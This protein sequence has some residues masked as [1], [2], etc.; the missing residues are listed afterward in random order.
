VSD[1]S[2]SVSEASAGLDCCFHLVNGVVG[3]SKVDRELNIIGP[4]ND[5]FDDSPYR[6]HQFEVYRLYDY[7]HDPHGQDYKGTLNT[8][9]FV[10]IK[11]FF[12]DGQDFAYYIIGSRLITAFCMGACGIQ[13]YGGP[14]F[15]TV[16]RVDDWEGY[17]EWRVN[18]SHS[19]MERF[20]WRYYFETAWGAWLKLVIEPRKV[21]S[22]LAEKAAR[23][24]RMK[25]EQKRATGAG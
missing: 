13:A 17:H 6:N 12:T 16:M 8:A 22:M 10:F 3:N 21:E 11:D 25:E 14:L 18:R 15:A 20:R 5:V 7:Q 2:P 9:A 19:E 4:L 23:L 1:I 24:Q